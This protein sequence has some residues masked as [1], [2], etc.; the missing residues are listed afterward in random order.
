MK[1]KFYFVVTLL[2]PA[3]FFIA[4]EI[5]L[6]WFNYGNDLSLFTE[7]EIR[8]KRYCVLNPDVKFRYFGNLPYTPSTAIQY[9]DPVKPSGAYRIFCLGGSTTVGYPY[10]FNASFSF[11]LS[12]R[13]K[14]AFPEKKIE[15][16]N[17]GMT[18]T[19]SFTV[20]DIVKELHSYQ[21][22]VILIYDG[23][24]EFYG[25]LGAASTQSIASSRFLTLLYLRL[26]H[27]KTFQL[28]NDGMQAFASFFARN[29]ENI[30]RGTLMEVLSRDQYVANE[31]ALYS[32]AFESFSENL[33]DLK[34]FCQSAG[35]PVIFGT[36]VS[37]LRDQPPFVS[38]HHSGSTVSESI[39]KQEYD[40]GINYQAK[41]M[42]DS[43]IGSF[44]SAIAADSF[45]ADAH[46]RLA[47]CLEAK[48]N[49]SEALK[50]Y[51]LAR[52]YD[53]LK[54]RA[55]SRFNTLI[56]SMD[57]MQ[58]TFVADIEKT[59]M[60][61]SQDSLVGNNLLTDHLHPTS[62]GY[63]L[64][65]KN[66]AE[67][68]K[69]HQLLFSE[70]EWTNADTV[71]DEALWK[72]RFVTELDEQ[73]AVQSIKVITSGWPFKNQK[74]TIEYLPASDTLNYLAQLLATGKLGWMDAHKLAAEYYK[75]RKELNS[76][77]REYKTMIAMYPHI[78]EL[79]LELASVYFQQR[80][81]D[82]MKAILTA[83]LNV[84]PTLKAYY[85]LA[86]IMMDKK[87]YNSALS[88]FEKMD[89]FYQTNKERIQNG[90]AMGF[91]YIK[92]GEFEKARMRVNQVLS[93][94][95][96]FP[97]ALLLLNEINKQLGK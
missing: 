32:S 22:D 50:E 82:E 94:K 62:Y 39:F 80:Y 2:L 68:M 25:A 27:L 49:N 18:A 56:R 13:L 8:G 63:F 70:K 45:Y 17:L 92:T 67:V 44:R 97:P 34:T 69:K 33:N 23:H 52:D 37:N 21:P 4:L 59:F 54:F 76:T 60:S 74:A 40:K 78:V 38:L 15:V 16:I 43:A 19:N 96:N 47:Q 30:S 36:Q 55:D 91:A 26:V 93:V 81:F 89:N 31:S 71:D 88:Y 79:Y 95:P 75:K 58:H 20:L 57:D 29:E 11:F 42:I 12:Q 85:G 35:I 65:A 41:G 86:H 3:V 10:Y 1:K 66:Y 77:E 14:E 53:A 48:R 46:Y 28:L 87:E 61:L 6:R 24:N 64:M 5:T 83:S 51:I 84:Q 90:L 7:E 72:N 73:M 9:F